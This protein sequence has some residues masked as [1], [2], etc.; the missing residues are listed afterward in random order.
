[1]REA[2]QLTNGSPFLAP[3]YRII[4]LPLEEGKLS[5]LFDLTYFESPLSMGIRI[6]IL[7]INYLHNI[8]A[9]I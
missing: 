2:L 4:T 5:N 1:M 3:V 8:G 9:L 6:G 7:R